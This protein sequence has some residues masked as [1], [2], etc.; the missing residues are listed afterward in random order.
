MQ[1]L[2]QALQRV[3]TLTTDKILS[4]VLAKN[5]VKSQIV[6]LNTVEQLY[7][8]LNAEGTRLESIGG[9]YK[10]STIRRKRAKG[11]PTD[12]VTLLDSRRFYKSFRVEVKPKVFEIAANYI[13]SGYDL[14]KRWGGKLAG[15]TDM[16][17]AKLR[18]YLIPRITDEVIRHIHQRR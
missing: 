6:R 2:R 12:R 4:E 9:G 15:L 14:R 10:P 18:S 11:Q 3:K 8:G 17:R 7:V 5:E 16:S 1:S 13:K